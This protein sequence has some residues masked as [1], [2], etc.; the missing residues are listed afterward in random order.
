MA[1]TWG[2]GFQSTIRTSREA[3]IDVYDYFWAR[4]C[5]AVECLLPSVPA[6][7]T[8]PVFAYSHHTVIPPVPRMPGLGEAMCRG[9]LKESA[10]ADPIR[11]RQ[12]TEG[13]EMQLVEAFLSRGLPEPRHGEHLTVLVEPKVEAAFPDIVAVYW[14][15]AVANQWTE[16]RLQL[17]NSDVRLLQFLYGHGPIRAEELQRRH[18]RRSLSKAVRR[19]EA[20]AVIEPIGDEIRLRPLTDI[21]ALR[22]LICVEAKVSAVSRA[23]DQAVR[24]TWFASEVYLL[25]PTLPVDGAVRHI[26]DVHG[27]GMVVPDTSID[28][29]PV[30]A[31]RGSLPRSYA[32]WLFN[33]WVWRLSRESL[34]GREYPARN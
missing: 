2:R 31:T 9:N 8:A 3:A 19:L 17:M 4:S 26:A 15:P 29:A 12:P 6:P 11:F 5:A 22:R 14:D 21:F 16:E 7:P 24:C 10:S 25:M 20:A 33:E 27:I 23:M 30:H 13:P 34:T 32:T 1:S 18:R 28:E